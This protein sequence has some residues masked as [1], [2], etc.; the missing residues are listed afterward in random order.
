MRRSRTGVI[1]SRVCGAIAVSRAF[2]DVGLQPFLIATPHVA[3]VVDVVAANSDGKVPVA[4]LLACDGLWDV[5]DDN[6]AAQTVVEVRCPTPR[7]RA[8]TNTHG[9]LQ[10]GNP[11][12]AAVKLRNN[13]FAGGS[14]DN[15]SVMV[16]HLPA[17]VEKHPL[18]LEQAF[19]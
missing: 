19:K 3:A 14:T 17:F 1:T 5:L 13:A 12:K 2:G 18:D 8:R 4:L 7:H 9:F 10:N 15:I 11:E 6:E 16:I